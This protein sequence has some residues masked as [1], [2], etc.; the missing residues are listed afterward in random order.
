MS[1]SEETITVKIRTLD[2]NQFDI[3]VT[4]SM[5]VGELKEK[6]SQRIDVPSDRQ[7]LIYQ[8]KLLKNS[9]NLASYRLGQ[10]HVI[11]LIANSPLPEIPPREEE[12]R[13]D[14][15]NDILRLAFDTPT[16]LLTRRRRRM[17]RR[18]EIDINERYE[19]LRQNIQTL[20]GLMTI[21]NSPSNDG[22]A[23]QAFDSDRR[24]FY[25]GQWV[26]VKDT[27]DQWLE[28]QIV[29]IEHTAR[30]TMVYIH[31]NGW[32][33]R[34]DEWIEIKNPRIQPFRTHTVQSLTSPMYSPFPNAPCD[35]ENMQTN[36]NHDINEYLLQTTGLLEQIKEMMER[37]Y[38]LNTIINHERISE[39][40]QPLRDRLRM[41]NLLQHPS[42][43]E[44]EVKSGPHSSYSEQASSERLDL[45]SPT[46]IYRDA[47]EVSSEQE[48]NLLT[49]QL[50]P[51][52]DRMGRMLTDLG[53]V[54]AGGPT[55]PPDDAASISSSLITNESGVSSGSRSAYQIPVMPSPAELANANPRAGSD[56]DIHIHAIF[57][58]REAREEA[59]REDERNTPCWR[60]MS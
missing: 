50:A 54:I 22:E 9:D 2:F 13:Q 20:D 57:S 51:L 12:P 37:Y 32:P 4:L 8:G 1:D 47:P 40:V 31:Y 10:G 14:S 60:Q 42:I 25:K 49:S 5:L 18:R 30:G 21:L 53:G 3:P 6:I 28:A 26:D 48:F 24:Q 35:A 52:L 29:E 43:P 34:W 27:V 7:R 11:Q 46:S 44:E 16:A 58:P 55:R 39:R 36:T 59:R 23:L 38:S 17:Q 41:V 19:A 45:L 33:N 56:I 15:F